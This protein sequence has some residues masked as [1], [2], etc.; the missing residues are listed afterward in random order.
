MGL[1]AEV[2]AKLV[3]RQTGA[4]DF[5]GPDFNPTMEAILNLASGTGLN[6]ADLAFFDERSVAASTND[7]IDLAGALSSA[8]GATI[9]M[10]EL[11]ALF[12]IN[13]PRSGTANVSDLTIGGGS[14]PVLGFLGGTTPT[15]G[16]IKPGGFLLLGAGHASGLGA[17]TGG[18]ADVLRVANGSGGTA[19]YQI[20]VLGRSA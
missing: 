14:N 13:A 20:G 8:F 2:R 19:L 16:P 6:Q 17:V 7:D 4:N 5:G 12:I 11:V 15:I 1:V 18:S 3:A 10:A 9:T